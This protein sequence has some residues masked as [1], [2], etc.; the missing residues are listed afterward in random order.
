MNARTVKKIA[1]LILFGALC[2]TL[3]ADVSP[4]LLESLKKSVRETEPK[5]GTLEVWQK[6]IFDE[7]VVPLAPR[8][9]RNYRQ[10][11]RG[12][13]AEVDLGAI[14]KYLT[15]YAPLIYDNPKGPTLKLNIKAE[16]NCTQCLEAVTGTVEM[17]K[18]RVLRRGFRLVESRQKADAD[19][20]LWLKRVP[21]RD[22]EAGHED[23]RGFR[24][25]L[26]FSS[27]D[28]TKEKQADLLINDPFET[29]TSS[30]LADWVADVSQRNFSAG[31]Q[32]VPSEVLF[33]VTQLRDLSHYA[34]IRSQLQSEAQGLF[35]EQAQIVLR[36]QK[37]GSAIFALPFSASVN[38][39][40]VLA[41]RMIKSKNWF[42]AAVRLMD[43]EARP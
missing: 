16:E 28:Y 18:R 39:P 8:F 2:T 12:V 34:Q 5:L 35:G 43:G 10:T 17:V 33:E 22:A 36:Q 24:V 40:K 6:K 7:E 4:Q 20:T 26:T 38:E 25:E 9:I 32:T 21:I 29:A 1:T 14:K 41:E 27:K 31:V 3:H 11:S 19:L 37:Q 15:F 23:E 30:V 42:G 13:S